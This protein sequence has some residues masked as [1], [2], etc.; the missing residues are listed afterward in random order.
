M[1]KAL[2][3]ALKK[4]IPATLWVN[5]R[6]LILGSWRSLNKKMTPLNKALY[7]GERYHCPICNSHLKRLKPY[8][9]DSAA[10][11]NKRVIGGGYRLNALC[12]VCFATDRDRLLYLYLS[13]KT[14]LLSA[15]VKLLHVAPEG[16]LSQLLHQHDNIDYL[17]ADLGAKTVMVKMDIT[18]IDFPEHTFDAILCNHV[19][20][21]IPDDSQAMSELYRVLKPGGWAILQVPMSLTLK[22]TYEDPTKTTPAQRVTAFGQDDHVR[23]YAMDYVL[24]LE[25][26]GFEVKLFQWWQHEVDFGGLDNCSGLLKDETLF[27]VTKG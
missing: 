1:I 26:A 4:V 5:A 9:V 18:K 16:H 3:T 23:I 6:K 24:R 13:K 15:P 21:H 25:A 17:T 2:K 8:G 22:Q 19:L 20:E 14:N 27:F 11:A 10:L 7:F 12:P